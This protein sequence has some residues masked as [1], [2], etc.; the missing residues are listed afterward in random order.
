MAPEVHRSGCSAG[1]RR[2]TAIF[3]CTTRSARISRAQLKEMRR[4]G[5]F[6][7]QP[8]VES[9]STHLLKIM[10]KH[11]TGM[12][13]VE[14]IKWCTYYGINN[15]YNIL[16][17]LRRRDAGRLSLQC[18][19]IAQDP[20]SSSRRTPSS[21]RAPTAARRCSSSDK[22]DRCPM[23]PAEC[24]RYLFPQARFN[25]ERV[26]Y[27]FDHDM[28]RTR[29]PTANTT[30]SFV[31]SSDGRKGGAAAG[32]PRSPTASHALQSSSRIA[33]TRHTA[34]RIFRPA[35]PRLY[36]FLHGRQND[37]RLAAD[38]ARPTGWRDVAQFCERRPDD[39]A[40]RAISQPRLPSNPYV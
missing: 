28:A 3:A 2:P 36:E 40:R 17:R 35:E 5:L 1:S 6:S 24:Y 10:K 39:P 15:L 11:T 23:R 7:V 26:S 27:Y 14:L 4:G 22:L 16:V 38:S 32:C 33:V 37:H 9:L 8:G 21:R 34:I 25:L 12:R 29:C 31:P 30:G 13:N 20:P 19:V 18:D